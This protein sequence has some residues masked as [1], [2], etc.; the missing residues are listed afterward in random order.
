MASQPLSGGGS[1]GRPRRPQAPA[2]RRAKGSAG[3]AA[4]KARGRAKLDAARAAL[5]PGPDRILI[6]GRRPVI[7]TLRAGHAVDRVLVASGSQQ[8][9]TLAELVALARQR[10]VPVEAVPRYALDERAETAA[11]QG[12]VA[13][14]APVRP[15]RL[16]ELLALPLGTKEPPLFL[17]L[18]GIEDPH[19]L[20]ALAR[21]ADAA[22]CHGMILPRHRSAPLGATALKAS[23]GALAHVP[24]AEVTSLARALERLREANVWCLGLDG[25]AE[26][27]L[28]DAD[29]ADEPVCVVVGG[30]GRGLGR[31]VR[32]TC[33]LLVRIPMAGKVG[34]LNASVAGALALFEIRRRR[35]A[36]A[37]PGGGSAR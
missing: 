20:G 23:A 13:V 1:D 3:R 34:S 14:A 32:Q 37:G 22:G 6:E 11:H 31:L 36:A 15:V 21:S 29:L 12:V 9:G 28:Y 8:E 33:D 10:G 4:K 26:R 2:E 16:E 18:D 19:N 7:E 25:A 30:E 17:A 24:V 35:D 5:R 27:S